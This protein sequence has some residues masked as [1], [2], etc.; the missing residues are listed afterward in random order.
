MDTGLCIVYSITQNV[1]LKIYQNGR[2]D[3]SYLLLGLLGCRVGI[4]E[5]VALAVS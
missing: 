3:S 4:T 2:W 1:R 5:L